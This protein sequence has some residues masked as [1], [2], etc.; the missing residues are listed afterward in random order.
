M[1]IKNRL[2]SQRALDIY[3]GIVLGL[4]ASAAILTIIDWA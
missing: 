2:Q 4:V 3:T 1:N